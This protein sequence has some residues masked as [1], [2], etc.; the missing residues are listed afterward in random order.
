MASGKFTNQDFFSLGI[1]DPALVRRFAAAGK[2]LIK[3]NKLTREETL[4]LFA[5]LVNDPQKHLRGEPLVRPLARL[6]LEQGSQDTGSIKGTPR[7]GKEPTGR[8]SPVLQ[9]KPLYYKVFGKEQIDP[10]SMNQMNTAM[11]L[12]VSNAGALMPDAHVGY[13]LPIG[14]V[15]AT[16]SS[17]VIPYAVGVDIA[18]RMCMSVYDLPV[19]MLAD[20]RDHLR[21]CLLNN[22]TFGVGSANR[23]HLDTGLFDSETWR[24]TRVIRDLKDLAFSQYGTSGAG[25]H[26]AEWGSLEVTAKD[27]LLQIPPGKYLAVLTHSGSRGF[28]ANICDHY[29]KIAREKC[30]LPKEAQHLSWLNL[31]SEEGKEYWIAMQLA[32]RYASANH[33][34][35]HNKIAREMG[36]QP[37]KML[38]NHHNFAWKDKL[39]EGPEVIIHRKGAT[40][41]G[42]DDIGII[43]GSMATPGFVVRGKGNASGLNSAAHGAGRVLSR[44]KAMKSITFR[45]MSQTL[46]KAGVELIGGHVDEAPEVYKDIHEV[47]AYQKNL[48]DVLARFQ[49]VIVRMAEP[50]RWR[51]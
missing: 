29:S 12:P 46:E 42:R 19:H 9:P 37:I 43:P 17:Y 6:L 40:P 44:K 45:K 32:G 34:E 50:G 31:K 14:G 26:F 35:I 7:A 16:D 24:S 3:R 33:H 41:A 20:K 5:E 36:L 27:E 28:G 4:A 49:P 38:E 8:P 22:T 30:G 23:R 11:R 1:Y 48:V 2:K 47:M 21:S 18:C 13:G 39:P 25:N 15:L 10:E 51:K